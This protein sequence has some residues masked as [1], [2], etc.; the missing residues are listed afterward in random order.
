MNILAIESSGKVAS[1][2]IWQDGKIFAEK[3]GAFRVTH[4]ETLMPLTAEVIKETG[5]RKEDID[6]IAVSGGPGSFTGLRIG[7]A[8]AKG[9]GLALGKDIVHVPTLDAMA[10]NFAGAAETI[11][12][13]MD[14]RRDQVYTGIYRSDREAEGSAQMRAELPGCAMAITEL[15]EHL[16]EK[17]AGEK[18]IFLGDGVDAFRNVIE[19]KCAN[20]YIF[21]EGDNAY[22]RAASVAAL[23]AA[24]AA[25]GKTVGAD[26]EAPEYLR[27]SQA[28]R[29]RAESQV[30]S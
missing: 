26:D 1:A 9:L 30:S 6:L 10:W 25:E 23:G 18:L 11:V 7:S 20:E 14:A 8:T 5:I 19:E 22:Q 4:S 3:M 2:A 17:H 16:A 24:L 15:L 28:E 29:V 21:A 13:V 12:P 27:P